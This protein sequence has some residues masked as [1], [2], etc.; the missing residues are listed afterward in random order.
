MHVFI[1]SLTV[2]PKFDTNVADVQFSHVFPK[3]NTVLWNST[4]AQ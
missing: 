1:Y 2:T 3:I 4:F